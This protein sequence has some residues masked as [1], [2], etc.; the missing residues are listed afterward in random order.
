MQLTK[1]AAA[2]R[3]RQAL[4]HGYFQDGQR[5]WLNCPQCR[6]RQETERNY[7]N[8]RARRDQPANVDP[9][10]GARTVYRQETVTEALFRMM[11]D[12]LLECGRLYAVPGEG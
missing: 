10:T 9:A 12:H 5:L 6:Q 2:G 11:R 4:R 1:T 3:A 7:R 8:F